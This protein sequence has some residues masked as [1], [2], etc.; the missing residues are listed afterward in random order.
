VVNASIVIVLGPAVRSHHPTLQPDHQ[1]LRQS[2]D[3]QWA[4]L[5]I[6]VTASDS[7]VLAPWAWPRLWLRQCRRSCIPRE[8]GSWSKW[9]SRSQRPQAMADG[10]RRTQTRQSFRP[11]V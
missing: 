9:R 3:S 4:C 1:H 11:A 8:G 5:P 7:P 10:A 6:A 2:P